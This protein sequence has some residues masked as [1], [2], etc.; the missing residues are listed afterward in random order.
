IIWG[1][2]LSIFQ[3]VATCCSLSTSTTSPKALIIAKK[4]DLVHSAVD[5]GVQDP[6][7]AWSKGQITCI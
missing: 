1:R 3:P 4:S 2:A 5:K 6:N 7:E